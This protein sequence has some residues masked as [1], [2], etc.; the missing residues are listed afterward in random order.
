MSDAVTMAAVWKKFGPKQRKYIAEVLYVNLTQLALMD[1]NKVEFQFRLL[2]YKHFE[3]GT[4]NAKV[5]HKLTYWCN[6]HAQD[7]KAPPT[8]TYFFK[9][10]RKLR[11]WVR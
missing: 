2:C 11:Y 10:E 8:K 7:L 6:W 4:R 3:Y 5:A 1:L 9:R